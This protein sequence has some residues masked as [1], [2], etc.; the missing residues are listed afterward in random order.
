MKLTDISIYQ[1]RT[2]LPLEGLLDAEDIRKEFS[3]TPS[4]GT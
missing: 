2:H 4:A 3:V 1:V